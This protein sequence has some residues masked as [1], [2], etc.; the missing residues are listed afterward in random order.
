MSAIR[1]LHI[2]RVVDRHGHV[3]HYLRVPGQKRV[4]LPGKHGSP[5]FMAAYAAG[6]ARPEPLPPA[7]PKV[8]PGSLDALVMSLYSSATWKA[9]RPT[10][11]AVYRRVIEGLRSKHG[12][13][14]I[15][16]MTP[17]GVRAIMA[18]RPATMAN[19]VLRLLGMLMRHAVMLGWRPDDPT[20]GVPKIAHKANGFKTWGEDDIAA[21]RA[22]HPSGTTPR[23]ALEL[24]LNTAQRRG[25]VVRMGRQHVRGGAIHIRQ[26]KTRT[27]VAVP[28]MRELADELA[29][30]PPGQMT[31]LETRGHS[32]TSGGF[33]TVFS[34]WCREAGLPPGLSPH[35]LRKACGVRLAEAGCTAHE[36]MAVLG[37]RT[38]AEAQRYTMEANRSRMAASAMAKLGQIGNE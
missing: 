30:L 27:D 28:I 25:D 34:G 23:L 24:L 2:Q 1:L 37:H 20:M 7:A 19:H 5:E 13:K 36:I 21:F 4:T 16:L 38:L 14:P 15:H 12:E 8:A 29:Q 17:A 22:R 10:T 32:R 9:L 6:I 18:N 33:Y 3:R 31:F 26:N 11:Q 35:G